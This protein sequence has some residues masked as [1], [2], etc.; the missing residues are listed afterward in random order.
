MQRLFTI[1]SSI[2]TPRSKIVGEALAA[3]LGTLS[4]SSRGVEEEVEGIVVR[5]QANYLHVKT[6]PNCDG[7]TNRRSCSNSTGMQHNCGTSE[8]LLCKVRTLLKKLDVKVLVGDKVQ[9]RR[10]D[11]QLKRGTVYNVS[12]RSSQLEDPAIANV[13]QVII[14]ISIRQP[15]VQPLQLTRFLLTAEASGLPVRVLINKTDL[16]DE[17]QL[18]FW[19]DRISGWGYTPYFLSVERKTGLEELLDLLSDKVSVLAGPSGVGKSSI[20]NTIRNE[21]MDN[22]INSLDESVDRVDDR[23]D[24]KS[25]MNLEERVGTV[26]SKTG[27][28]KHTTR[29]VSLL[30]IPRNGLL[31]DTPGLN[32]TSLMSIEDEQL[33]AL[34]P[35]IRYITKLDDNDVEEDETKT[36]LKRT[37]K[38]CGPC[39]FSDCTHIAEPECNVHSQAWERYDHYLYYRNE[40]VINNQNKRKKAIKS[41]LK[42]PLKSVSLMYKTS[43]KTGNVTEKSLVPLLDRKKHRRSSRNNRKKELK[44][45]VLKQITIDDYDDG[46]IH[47]ENESDYRM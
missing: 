2:S 36:Q 26:G 5:A 6:I 32:L 3:G 11:W 9:L 27:L 21:N 23:I 46:Q 15:D 40:I 7:D 1:N 20:I 4:V 16:C 28:G 37:I 38:V 17:K 42:G 18:S 35:E 41:K 19:K 22:I 24:Q 39:G 47:G 34:F 31:A 33:P 45:F 29:H 25:M 13:E 10:V 44:E 12:S 8:I 14:V 43:D 30:N